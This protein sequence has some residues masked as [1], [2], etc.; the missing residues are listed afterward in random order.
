MVL[1]GSMT[2]GQAGQCMEA[3]AA[4]RGVAYSIFNIIDRV[5]S[6]FITQLK[7]REKRKQCLTFRNQRLMR[8]L[9]R[10]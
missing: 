4:A 2:L 3:L 5:W 8:R 6:S 7:H 10:V 9:L 1:M